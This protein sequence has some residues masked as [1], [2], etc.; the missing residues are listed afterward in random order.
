MSPTTKL[1]T[2]KPVV[3]SATRKRIELTT[4]KISPT[5]QTTTKLPITKET[6]T[7]L[8]FTFPT[9]TKKV[10]KT[11]QTPVNI[12]THSNSNPY[13]EYFNAI[14]HQIPSRKVVTADNE[15]ETMPDIEII[16]FVAHDAIDH[17]KFES[18]HRNPY[19]EGLERDYFA[20]SHT[21]KP[22]RYNNKFTQHSSIYDDAVV[23][24]HQPSVVG[25]PNPHE[26]I[27]NGPYYFETNENQFE[28][29]SPPSEQDFIGKL[30]FF[31]MIVVL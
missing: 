21:E 10:Q 18:Y 22:F 24:E 28:A 20:S 12:I 2:K 26:R 6:T 11:T 14:K 29:F 7:K 3:T 23:V 31:A 15:A 27:D 8:P 4:I 25:F 1:T 17:D 13:D 30:C 16:P 19:E 9:T 5:L